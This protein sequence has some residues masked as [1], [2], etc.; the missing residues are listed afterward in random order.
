MYSDV[1][2]LGPRQ[3]WNVSANHRPLSLLDAVKTVSKILSLTKF[4][5]EEYQ[6]TDPSFVWYIRPYQYCVG[7]FPQDKE[8]VKDRPALLKHHCPEEKDSNT[9]FT[10]QI[11]VL[12]NIKVISRAPLWETRH[13]YSGCWRDSWCIAWFWPE[14]FFPSHTRYMEPTLTIAFHAILF[15]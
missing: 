6:N 5:G 11:F 2:S 15:D 10:F 9:V 14:F 4:Q 3:F 8:N 1:I 13:H 7:I 12:L